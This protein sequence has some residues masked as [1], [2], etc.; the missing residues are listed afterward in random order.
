MHKRKRA[1][2]GALKELQGLRISS[3]VITSALI[4][5]TQDKKDYKVIFQKSSRL[6]AEDIEAEATLDTLGQGSRGCKPK[7]AELIQRVY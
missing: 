4:E 3:G 6:D 5:K 1:V 7:T 2:E